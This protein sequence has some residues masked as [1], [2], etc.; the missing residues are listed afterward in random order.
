MDSI[1]WQIP[2]TVLIRP[3][4]GE[5]LVVDLQ[6][7]NIL[8]CDSAAEGFL[9]FFRLPRRFSDYA[10][11]V[12]W[13]SAVM[14]SDEWEDWISFLQSYRIIEVRAVPDPSPVA[15]CVGRTIPRFVR[16]APEE[17]RLKSVGLAT[18]SNSTG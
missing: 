5:T 7:G 12:G 6:T 17:M 3:L 9:E 11:A 14:E 18:S 16:V 1:A 10:Q 2:E 15:P 13:N 4:D 8:Y